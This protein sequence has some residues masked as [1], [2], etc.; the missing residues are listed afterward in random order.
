MQLPNSNHNLFTTSGDVGSLLFRTICLSVGIAAIVPRR[1]VQSS[2]PSALCEGLELS[3]VYSA[4]RVITTVALPPTSAN[5]LEAPPM[6]TH[7]ARP[8]VRLDTS[9]AGD[10]FR[11]M[12]R[13]SAVDIDESRIYDEMVPWLLYSICWQQGLSVDIVSTYGMCLVR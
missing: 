8:F 2:P 1:T 5:A 13:S 4:V 6:W 11:Y 12:R 7:S 9:S 3:S 10:A